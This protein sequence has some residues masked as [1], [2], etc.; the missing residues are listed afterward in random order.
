M[1]ES[2][3]QP[4]AL[5]G[6]GGGG[7]SLRFWALAVVT[8]VGAGIGAGLLMKLLR[9]VQHVAW[10]YWSGEFITAVTQASWQRRILVLVL[11]GLVAAAGRYLIA[12]EPGGHAGELAE[13]LWFRKGQLPFVRSI[14]RAMLSMVIVGLGT[15]LG[16]EAGAKLTGGAIASTLARLSELSSVER[17]LLVACGAGA[18]MGA[19]YNV[20]FGGALF[21]LEVLLGTLALPLIPAAF[22]CSFIATCASWLLVPDKATYVVPAYEFSAGQLV[23]AVFAGP[24]CGLAG[25]LYV[26][27]ISWA[28][29]LKPKGWPVLVTPV[30]VLTALGA[31]ASVYPQLLGNGKGVAQQA[32]SGELGLA[33]IVPLLLLKPC[34]T[35]ACLGSGAP[36]GLFTP[37][38]TFGALLGALLGALWSLLWPGTPLGSY[39]LI[40]A[41]AMLAAAMQSPIAAIVLV[42]E[43]APGIHGLILPLMLAV[44]GAALVQRLIEARSI[45]SGRIHAGRMLAEP[46]EKAPDV[47]F[48][49][50]VC[51]DYDVISA[52]ATYTEV[53]RALGLAER[54]GKPLYV[55]AEE[56]DLVGFI[57]PSVMQHK[58]TAPLA[59]STAADL[60]QKIE[61]V[62]ASMDEEAVRRMLQTSDA[63]ELPVVEANTTRL[64]GVVRQ[65]T[66]APPR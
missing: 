20:P 48:R 9:L 64:V 27:A 47:N 30:A 38:L 49:W 61:P 44:G 8:G 37:T 2:S 65:D 22:L 17:R 42:L 62:V 28:D 52:A 39:A 5:S 43:L 35:A 40:G 7:L 55:V 32:F 3:S 41:G 26:V 45:Y 13:A 34:I 12:S 33:L 59:I 21:A 58:L 18:G 16:R 46:V 36:G 51:G 29:A 63:P 11:A 4:N 6:A 1:F 14:S 23:W 54:E 57:P 31:I 25:A 60:A 53:L 19:V 66:S 24:L 10:S 56:G 15:S 50:P